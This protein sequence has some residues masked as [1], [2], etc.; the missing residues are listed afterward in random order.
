MPKQLVSDDGPPFISTEI[1]RFLKMNWIK[2]IRSSAY[3]PSS[4][5]GAKRSVRT[6]KRRLKA[7]HRIGLE[8]KR[9]NSKFLKI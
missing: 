8:I 7:C 4:N 1:G 6:I 5:G 3:H 2:K 9:S